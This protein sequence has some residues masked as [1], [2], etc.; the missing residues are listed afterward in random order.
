MLK[1]TI[2]R[3]H[4]A[5]YKAVYGDVDWTRLPYKPTPP[6]Q[7]R[8]KKRTGKK[9]YKVFLILYTERGY[10][11]KTVPCPGLKSR[12]KKCKDDV[13]IIRTKG[14][15]YYDL[16]NALRRYQWLEDN[17]SPN[18]SVCL[19]RLWETDPNRDPTLRQ[20]KGTKTKK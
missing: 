4:N 8:S 17:T 2:G 18:V 5:V 16:T 3:I 1:H 11:G 20:S 19:L 6:V 9:E 7:Q 14:R 15:T 12:R 13:K 10:G